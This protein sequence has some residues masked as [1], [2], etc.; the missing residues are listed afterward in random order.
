MAQ[1]Q[2]CLLF[3]NLPEVFPFTERS[4]LDWTVLS[5]SSLQWQGH[6][7]Q[8]ATGA[9]ST[10]TRETRRGP[11]AILTRLCGINAVNFLGSHTRSSSEKVSK[12]Q[13]PRA[14]MSGHYSMI[15]PIKA[16]IPPGALWTKLGPQLESQRSPFFGDHGAPV[17][18]S[19]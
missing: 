2:L 19:P 5:S 18:R 15:T 4:N 9:H 7:K 1:Q 3:H 16:K 6:S 12:C 8:C 14:L 10:C 11:R 13:G 17:H